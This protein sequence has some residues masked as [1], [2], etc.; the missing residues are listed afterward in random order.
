VQGGHLLSVRDRVWPQAL[1]CWEALGRRSPGRGSGKT[2]IK[3]PANRKG[4]K[5]RE[6]EK[7]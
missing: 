1:V 3:G 5:K 7:E 6:R 2:G 4:K